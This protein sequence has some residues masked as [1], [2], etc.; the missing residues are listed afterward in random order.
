MKQPWYRVR[1]LPESERQPFEQWLTGKTRPWL[2][3]E[4]ETEQDGY[5]YWEYSRW[6]EL[7][8]FID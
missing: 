5:F 8:P 7:K 2:D 6:R 4:P 3:G 1:D